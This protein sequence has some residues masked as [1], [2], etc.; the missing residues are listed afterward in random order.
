MQIFAWSCGLEYLFDNVGP[1]DE[2]EG[3]LHGADHSL[4]C[5]HLNWF[6]HVDPAGSDVAIP[7]HEKHDSMIT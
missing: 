7:L 5:R 6:H 2:A 4:I 1:L 3:F